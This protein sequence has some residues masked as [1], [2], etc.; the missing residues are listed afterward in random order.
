MRWRGRYWAGQSETVGSVRV[1]NVEVS[2][3]DRVELW[4]REESQR[5]GMNGTELVRQLMR[6]GRERPVE[7]GRR[8]AQMGWVVGPR[9]GV[10]RI[11]KSICLG[12]VRSGQPWDWK[13]ERIRVEV[14]GDRKG[15][16]IEESRKEHGWSK[17]PGWVRYGL[18]S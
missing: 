9:D 2:H 8:V 1:R 4:W 13:V 12:K 11:G 3:K 6:V 10:V 14:N 7:T 18:S 5:L 15:S 17:R 16:R